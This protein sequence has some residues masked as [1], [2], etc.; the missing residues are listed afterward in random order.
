MNVMTET[1]GVV[2]RGI[3]AA[4]K[5][6]EPIDGEERQKNSRFQGRI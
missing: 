5:T 2:R 4:M 3:N 1:S 6:M